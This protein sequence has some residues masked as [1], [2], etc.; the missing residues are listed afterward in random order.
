MWTRPKL[1]AETCLSCRVI[2][3]WVPAV[4]MLL[5]RGGRRRD[6]TVTDKQRKCPPAAAAT[7]AAEPGANYAVMIALLLWTSQATV[8]VMSLY[9]P[10]PPQHPCSPLS[11]LCFLPLPPS[12]HMFSFILRHFLWEKLT[13]GTF[14]KVKNAFIL[15]EKSGRE[16]CNWL[17]GT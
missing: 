5:E 4:M 8:P 14:Q 13:S 2:V 17:W 16:I 9:L 10:H 12:F 3:D 6:N 15:K 7:A 11:Y 1:P